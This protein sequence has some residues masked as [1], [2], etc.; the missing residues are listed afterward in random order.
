MAECK[1]A[2]VLVLTELGDSDD[3]KPP[4]GKTR[5]WIKRKREKGYF[6]ITAQDARTVKLRTK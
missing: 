5:E 1:D 2:V 4:L 6:F 3:E